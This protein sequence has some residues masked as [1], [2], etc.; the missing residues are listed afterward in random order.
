MHS[1]SVAKGAKFQEVVQNFNATMKQEFGVKKRGAPESKKALR[2]KVCP[3]CDMKP[4]G[5]KS[6][7][8]FS[9]NY[10]FPCICMERSAT[11]F[12]Q[13]V[14]QPQASNRMVEEMIHKSCTYF[15][16]V[17]EISYKGTKQERTIVWKPLK[18]STWNRNNQPTC[19]NIR[20]TA[21]P[22]AFVTVGETDCGDIELHMVGPKMIKRKPYGRLGAGVNMVSGKD[23]IPS[24]MYMIS[25]NEKNAEEEDKLEQ[26]L[27]FILKYPPPFQGKINVRFLGQK[28]DSSF[29]SLFDFDTSS[30]VFN[31][32]GDENG[33]NMWDEKE[34]MCL[35][36]VEMIDSSRY[37][38]QTRP[39]DYTMEDKK[40]STNNNE[41]GKAFAMSPRNNMNNN[42]ANEDV[43]MNEQTKDYLL[44]NSDHF[45]IS[46]DLHKMLAFLEKCITNNDLLSFRNF[47]LHWGPTSWQ[48]LLLTTNHN[49]ENCLHWIAR[50]QA[51]SFY[52]YLE[53]VFTPDGLLELFC[54]SPV[55]QIVPFQSLFF[56]QNNDTLLNYMLKAIQ[57][58]DH[59]LMLRKLLHHKSQLGTILT[60]GILFEKVNFLHTVWLMLKKYPSL[61][62]A[63]EFIM[64][65]ENIQCLG[66]MV[67]T[68]SETQEKYFCLWDN[69]EEERKKHQPYCKAQD[70]A[71][72]V[73]SIKNLLMMK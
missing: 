6:Q 14:C 29:I 65:C 20:I 13:V 40:H 17:C 34:Y 36:P 50:H 31:E 2:H 15:Y 9:P 59:C 68:C 5:E 7:C 53:R 3:K 8:S 35:P 19:D 26:G 71:K 46:H 48:S 41:M 24:L 10:L 57:S 67:L 21:V 54:E 47:G 1:K 37:D 49:N 52:Q 18:K 66:E 33:N 72:A 55:T 39:M 22:T 73:I 56:M 32:S 30:P 69:Y 11:S 51:L 42:K 16:M 60:D 58:K 25:D 62:T 27:M 61:L 4:I 64:M 70:V 43:D 38:Y 44:A 45:S 23:W 12:I 28:S 63:Q